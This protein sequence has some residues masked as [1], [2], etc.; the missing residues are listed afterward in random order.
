MCSLRKATV[1]RKAGLLLRAATSVLAY[2][3]HAS[4]ALFRA[5]TSSRGEGGL[6]PIRGEYYDPG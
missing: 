5:C 3:R 6:Q 1:T 2:S 4:A